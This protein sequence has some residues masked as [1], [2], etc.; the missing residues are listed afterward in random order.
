MHELHT[1]IEITAPPQDVWSTL[2]DFPAYS[3]WNPFI[4]HVGGVPEEGASLDVRIRPPSAPAR[5]VRATVTVVRPLRELRCRMRFLIPAVFEAEHWCLLTPLAEGEVR[6]E[7]HLRIGGLAAPFLRSRVDRN[8]ARGFREMNAAL[9][10]RIERRLAKDAGGPPETPTLKEVL[11]PDEAS[12][13]PAEAAGAV[14]PQVRQRRE[15]NA[16]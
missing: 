15:A 7:Q 2:V 3:G 5:K 12:P 9:K 8:I 13:A 14:E 6:F 16:G 1:D 4:R 11:L 10:G